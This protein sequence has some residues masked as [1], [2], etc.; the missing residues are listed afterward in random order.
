MQRS[1]NDV[2]VG[3]FVLLGAVAVLFLALKAANLLT[4]SFEKTYTVNARFDN[5]GGL[6]PQAAVRSAGVVVGR[7]ASIRFDDQSFQATVEL[8]LEE[9][10]IHVTRC[11]IQLLVVDEADRR[12][13]L[14][15]APIGL[16]FFSTKNEV[17]EY[18]NRVSK[19]ALDTFGLPVPHEYFLA[20]YL[21]ELNCQ[22]MA[23]ND[24]VRKYF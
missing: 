2:W 10:D 14:E 23:P 22:H 1:K 15:R 11:A 5:I 16:P 12:Y 20:K 21:I 13:L 8:A 24:A 9:A 18:N 3:L 19:L 7:V 4:W 6:K 17:Q